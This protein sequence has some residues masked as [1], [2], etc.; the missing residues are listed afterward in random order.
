M[1]KDNQQADAQE[2]NPDLP[3]DE[4]IAGQGLESP[5][6]DGRKTSEL[7]GRKDVLTLASVMDALAKTDWNKTRAADDLGVSR[8]AI[9]KFIKTHDLKKPKPPTLKQ[10]RMEVHLKN[11]ERMEMRAKPGPV[12]QGEPAMETQKHPPATPKQ[13]QTTPAPPSPEITDAV[14]PALFRYML[15]NECGLAPACRALGHKVTAVHYFMCK[16]GN[17]EI[18]NE[19]LRLRNALIDMSVDKMDEVA[20]DC[21]PVNYNAQRVKLLAM[22]WKAQAL[23]PDLY[24]GL[25]QDKNRVPVGGEKTL[26]DED[27]DRRIRQTLARLDT[28]EGREP[29]PREAEAPADAVVPGLEVDLN[30]ERPI[31]GVDKF[32][33]P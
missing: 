7:M 6:S 16:K 10:I 1:D 27:L 4:A 18:H 2:P 11:K 29:K 9:I 19:Y 17:E 24:G 25:K 32:M 30:I 21:D 23:R 14:L 12:N 13:Q 8:P 5:V 33:K 31:V 26:S 22:Q 15:E 28:L 3:G 20:E